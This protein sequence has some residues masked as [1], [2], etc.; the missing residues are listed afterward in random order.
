MEEQ[1]ENEQVGIEALP[2][3]QN[4]QF[5]QLEPA[6]LKVRMWTVMIIFTILLIPLGIF[7]YHQFDE[8]PTFVLAII[9]GLWF[10]LMS[11]SFAVTYFGFS[12]KGY[13]LRSKDVL[14]RS[15]LIW[16]S[17]TVIPFNRV[18]HCEVSQGPIARWMKVASL[19]VFTAGGTNSD[20]TIPG[21]QPNVAYRMKD[22]IIQQTGFDEEE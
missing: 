19:E 14:Y 3:V 22:F 1:F 11:W 5:I 9:G 13:A 4:I 21:L 17:Q 8:L 6:Y 2:R 20:M 15:G 18:Q 10:L 7:I 12:K 16:R